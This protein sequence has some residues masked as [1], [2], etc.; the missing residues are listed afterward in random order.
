MS[1]WNEDIKRS[2]KYCG[3]NVFIGH[4]TI[5]TCPEKVILYDNIRIDPFCLITTGLIVLSNC[6]ITSHV[7]IGG[8]S[9][10]TVK[11]G[12][13]TFIG[14]SSKLFCASEDYSGEEGPD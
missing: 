6:Q 9:R 12:N 5:F 8:G 14:Y 3:K 4:N 10:H 11:L 13:W 2:F 1:S 7:V